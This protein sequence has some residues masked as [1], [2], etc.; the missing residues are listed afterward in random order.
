M[1]FKE[2]VP[3]KG[4]LINLKKQYSLAKEGYELLQRKRNILLH[5]LINLIERAS[6]I[7]QQILLI[8]SQAYDALQNAALDI[9]MEFI[10]E[11]SHSVT[12]ENSIDIRFRSVMGIEVPEVYAMVKNKEVQ[13][14]YGIYRTNS[15]LDRAYIGFTKA[16]ELATNAAMIENAVYRLAYEAKRTQKRVSSLE[17][18]V[19]PSLEEGIKDIQ[20][21]LEEIEREEF[22]K[23]KKLKKQELP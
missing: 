22:F 9:G 13:M 10:D 1:I 12:I 5:E 2:S 23:L 21:A 4:N 6:I 20:T 7:Q 8:F 17:N 3:T 19:I 16:L 18:I 15:S 14:P 11:I